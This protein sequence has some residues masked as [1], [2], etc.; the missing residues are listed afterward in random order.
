MI[1][2][3]WWCV[4]GALL[5][6]AGWGIVSGRRMLH[7]VLYAFPSPD[8][9]PAHRVIQLRDQR[10]EPFDV[11]VLDAAQPTAAVL[12]F[13]GY[14]ANRLQLLALADGLRQGGVT[15]L[16]PD[17][18]GHGRRGGR[19]SFGIDDIREIDTLLQWINTDATVQGRPLGL[20]GYSMGGAIGCYVASRYPQ[21]RI[22]VTDSTYARL[23]PVLAR[24]IRRLYRLPMIPWA[25]VTWWTVQIWLRH[26]LSALDPVALGPRCRQ[27][28]LCI[29]GTLDQTVPVEHAQQLFDRWAGPKEQWIHAHAGHVG[30]YT[31]DPA[32]YCARVQA[33]LRRWLSDAPSSI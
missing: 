3:L 32:G 16:L 12:A 22:L 15:V 6:L 24:S 21:F 7:P 23:F 25:L 19:S 31:L 14:H 29:H 11:W 8:P 4:A 18:R 10:G 13:H 20:L 27:P 9:M 2:L 33:F 17:L 5:I 1:A 28:L 26:R 30:A